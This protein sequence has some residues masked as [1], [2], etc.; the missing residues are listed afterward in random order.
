MVSPA[1]LG[2]RV[3]KSSLSQKTYR[4]RIQLTHTVDPYSSYVE[5]EPQLL[6]LRMP[7]LDC[8]D[9]TNV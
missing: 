8:C 3:L 4:E 6:K 2:S 5:E 9:P 7:S 1:A